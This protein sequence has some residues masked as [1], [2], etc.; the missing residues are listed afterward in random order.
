[1]KTPYLEGLTPYASCWL[2]AGGSAGQEVVSLIDGLRQRAER[3]ESLLARA[4]DGSPKRPREANSHS[5][6]LDYDIGQHLQREGW[7]WDAINR[8]WRLRAQVSACQEH[9]TLYRGEWVEMRGRSQDG[10]DL[11]DLAA[12]EASLPWNQDD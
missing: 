9:G 11:A 6:Q 10:L 3:A 8:Q 7:V 1:M 12:D 4:Q 2:V 5:V